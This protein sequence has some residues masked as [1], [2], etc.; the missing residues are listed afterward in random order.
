MAIPR[1]LVLLAEAHG[2]AG[3]ASEGLGVL[4]EA[5]AMVRRSGDRNSEAAELYRIRGE[6]LL[7][8]SG[9]Q[10]DEAEASLRR[11]VVIARRQQAKSPELRATMSLAR[12]LDK[13]GKPEEARAMLAAI[14]GWFTEG[15]DTAD[16]KEAKLLLEQL[17]GQS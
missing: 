16:L 11:A 9:E 5:L 1:F 8:V 13:Q 10:R 2:R 14:C 12:L 15:F 4:D 17:D 6:L 3:Q 7:A